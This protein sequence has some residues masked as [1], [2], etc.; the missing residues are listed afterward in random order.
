M[1]LP[2]T[3]PCKP[4]KVLIGIG[5]F[6]LLLHLAQAFIPGIEHLPQAVS[7]GIIV[8][9]FL[10][11]MAVFLPEWKRDL[12][13]FVK[14]CRIYAKFFFP[15]FLCFLPLY[16]AVSI[17]VA[18]VS[19][20]EAANQQAIGKLPPGML[21]VFSVFVAPLQEEVLYRGFLRRIISDDI[22]Y[23]LVSG[24]IF[25][26]AHVLL[27]EQTLPQLLY[28][29]AYSFI[30]SFLAWLYVKTDNIC[31]PVM[32]HGCYNLLCFILLFV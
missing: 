20:T 3:E 31:V 5:L 17:A 29:I 9:F 30:G 22:F 19:G 28:I 8:L 26:L 15:K 18:L 23:I 25:G 6:L 14:N 13:V 1:T 11:V 10:A 7:W 32:G 16:F 21:F 4:H 2:V 12:P 27:P 24:L